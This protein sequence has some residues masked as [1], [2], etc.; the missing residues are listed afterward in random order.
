MFGKTKAPGEILA[1]DAFKTFIDASTVM[2]GRIVF[3]ESIR[4]DGKVLGNVEVEPGATGSV[5]VGPG[6]IVRGDIVAHRVLIAGTVQGNIRALETVQLMDGARVTGDI[7]YQSI[8]IVQGASVNGA[9]T[10]SAASSSNEEP[11]SEK[12]RKLLRLAVDGGGSS[13][14]DVA[15]KAGGS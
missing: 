4:I 10:E 9:L 6:A 14:S 2:Q 3:A 1:I 5:A 8:S 7:S 15:V 12:R 11:S 13:P